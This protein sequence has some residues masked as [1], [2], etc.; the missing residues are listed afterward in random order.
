MVES[1][2]MISFKSTCPNTITYRTKIKGFDYWFHTSK[3][4]WEKSYTKEYREYVETT[5]EE[6]DML[7]K[8]KKTAEHID[9]KIR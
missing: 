7:E 3:G 6:I 8:M 9:F 1:G 4:V 2:K 5:Q